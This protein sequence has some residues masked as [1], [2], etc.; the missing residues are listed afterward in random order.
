MN[1]Q[2]ADAISG[3]D[4]Q[5]HSRDKGHRTGIISAT[6]QPS[7]PLRPLS[8]E[9]QVQ[10]PS[11][12]D[13]PLPLYLCLQD[14]HNG[15]NPIGS[16]PET[17]GRLF[18]RSEILGWTEKDPKAGLILEY[19]REGTE[20]QT[21]VNPLGLG[22]GCWVIPADRMAECSECVTEHMKRFVALCEEALDLP[23]SKECE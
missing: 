3:T 13:Q 20:D 8:Q 6:I 7:T 23:E 15:I 16:I 22:E 18:L 2:T 19:W 11:P 4:V 14:Y 21:L 9:V 1:T 5:Y 12:E 17:L 10:V